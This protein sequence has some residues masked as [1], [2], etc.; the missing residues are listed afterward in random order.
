[1]VVQN[2]NK[3]NRIREG[4]DF[5]VLN[6]ELERSQP[7]H[8]ILNTTLREKFKE[9]FEELTTQELADQFLLSENE[10]V[11][12]FSKLLS[13]VEES[14]LPDENNLIFAHTQ[15]AL[16]FYKN[17]FKQKHQTLLFVSV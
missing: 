13:F 2:K 17:Y 3:Y 9:H 15:K 1:M 16:R 11:N 6:L 14:L 8:D 12:A 10:E 5:K 7:C 4:I